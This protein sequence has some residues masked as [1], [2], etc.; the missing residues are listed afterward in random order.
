[1]ADPRQTRVVL[2]EEAMNS[3]A[4]SSVNKRFPP[5]ESRPA[6]PAMIPLLREKRVRHTYR[7]LRIHSDA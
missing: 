6:T 4:K 5:A 3:N 7:P 1:M 2:F